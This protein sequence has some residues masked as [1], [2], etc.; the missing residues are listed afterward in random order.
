MKVI[1]L[2]PPKVFASA[3]TGVIDIFN[4]A[5]QVMGRQFF[6]W[7]IAALSKELQV[8]SSQGLTIQCDSMLG[9]LK[10]YDVLVW[11]GAQY[12]SDAT[13]WQQCKEVNQALSEVSDTLKTC[14]YHLAGCCGVAYLGATGLLDQHKITASWWL[15]PFFAKYF[16]HIDFK[17]DET[18]LRSNEVYTAG[19]AHSYLHLILTFVCDRVGKEVAEQVASW[20]AIPQKSSSQNQFI[21]LSVL[22]DHSDE[23]IRAV[24][25]L[26]DN[27]LAEALSL[28]RLAEFAYMS[29]RTLIRRFKLHV[30]MT[31]MDYVRL[32]RLE[33]SRHLLASSNLSQAQIA[34]QVG[35][36]DPQALARQFK[37][38]F[39][40]SMKAFR[41]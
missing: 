6:S 5:N 2:C 23:Q 22:Q 30:G 26:I 4:V 8:V 25:S 14:R 19:A 29:E 18:V 37:K 16:P 36:Q 1:L 27:N 21:R 9:E 28:K 20:L 12:S 31:P 7:K 17:A 3:L 32:V 34:Y 38:H 15:A 39:Q 40:M 10:G 33:K 11:V 13:L 41:D 24:Q 35:Y